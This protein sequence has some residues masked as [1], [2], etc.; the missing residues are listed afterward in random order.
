MVFLAFVGCRREPGNPREE[1]GQSESPL[2][3]PGFVAMRIASPFRRDRPATVIHARSPPP[4][5]RADQFTTDRTSSPL[6]PR[7]NRESKLELV[8]KRLCLLDV[9]LCLLMASTL[10]FA[11]KELSAQLFLR[12]NMRS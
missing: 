12:R 2:A 9:T 5:R 3:E 10:R 6:K 4:F 11:A 7:I 8:S 1:E